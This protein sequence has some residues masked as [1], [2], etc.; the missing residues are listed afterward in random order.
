MIATYCVLAIIAFDRSQERV[1]DFRAKLLKSAVEKYLI[2]S[3]KYPAA[4]PMV[5]EYLE[6]G[7]KGLSS[8][9]GL[10]FQYTLARADS[11]VRVHI[12]TERVVGKETR[13]YGNKPPEKK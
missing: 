2:E 5:A 13:I 1:A 12:W 8:P 11:H 6:E 7:K 4:L 3:G 9:W 10:P